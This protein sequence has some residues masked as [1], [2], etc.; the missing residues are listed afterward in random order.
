MSCQPQNTSNFW[1]FFKT[2][3]LKTEEWWEAHIEIQIAFI[4]LI[5][6]FISSNLL[7]RIVVKINDSNFRHD[8]RKRP[9]A[10][11][12]LKY[13]HMTPPDSFTISTE[14]KKIPCNPSSVEF[15]F[16]GIFPFGLFVMQLFQTK[17]NF[18]LKLS[19]HN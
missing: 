8:D 1:F 3:Y 5:H 12:N 6:N 16:S 14:P 10:C 9:T 11:Y 4:I 15:I 7:D 19:K 18:H 2:T 13:S 17:L